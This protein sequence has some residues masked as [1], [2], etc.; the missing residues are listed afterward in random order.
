RVVVSCRGQVVAEHHR[1]WAKQ[2]VITDPAHVALAGQ[3]RRDL[4]RDAH[5]RRAGHPEAAGERGPRQHTDGHVVELRA[6]PDYD[7]LFG[8]DFAATTTVTA[9][10]LAAESGA[11]RTE[12]ETRP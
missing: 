1:S 11:E 8:V 4:A 6:L 7:T 3:M 9:D 12:R 2:A 5:R 10:G